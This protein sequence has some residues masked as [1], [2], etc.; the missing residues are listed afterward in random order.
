MRVGVDTTSSQRL[1]LN[2]FERFKHLAGCI[3]QLRE[4]ALS[5]TVTDFMQLEE[6][7]SST[8]DTTL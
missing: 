5:Q 4:P 3:D 6:S 1:F 8:Q 7:L 2:L